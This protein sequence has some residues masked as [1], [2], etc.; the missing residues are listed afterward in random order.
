[1]RK[2]RPENTYIDKK[3]KRKSEETDKGYKG[4]NGEDAAIERG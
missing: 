3:K 4:R 2:R 1:M